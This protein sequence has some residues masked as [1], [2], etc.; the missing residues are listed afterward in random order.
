MFAITPFRLP[1]YLLRFQYFLMSLRLND[2]SV[3]YYKQGR[4]QIMIRSKM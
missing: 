3:L 1:I 2:L 4:C